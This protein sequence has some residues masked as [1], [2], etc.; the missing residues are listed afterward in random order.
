MC[1]RQRCALESQMDWFIVWFVLNNHKY[2]KFYICCFFFLFNLSKL[3]ELRLNFEFLLLIWFAIW[4][5]LYIFDIM[6][7]K[8]VP[9]FFWG[10]NGQYLV[11]VALLIIWLFKSLLYVLWSCLCVRFGFASIYHLKY[12][13]CRKTHAIK[14]NKI[15]VIWN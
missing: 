10:F 9:F 14:I 2:L 3:L 1:L 7:S 12:L 6:C 13:I 4:W 11:W 5:N 15:K 8:G